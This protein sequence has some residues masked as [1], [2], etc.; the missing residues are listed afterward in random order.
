MFD[1]ETE[2]PAGKMKYKILGRHDKVS[3]QPDSD[4]SELNQIDFLP[5]RKL[6][7]VELKFFDSPPLTGIGDLI[8]A[9][10]RKVLAETKI[11]RRRIEKL[12]AERPNIRLVK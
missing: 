5:S 12:R 2:V 8:R 3:C 4:K 9:A 1:D 6:P 7:P 11:K 10:T